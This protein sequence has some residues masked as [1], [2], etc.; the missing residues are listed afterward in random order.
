M[1]AAGMPCATV[2]QLNPMLFI[3]SLPEAKVAYAKLDLTAD[4]TTVAGDKAT[5]KVTYIASSADDATRSFPVEI[6]IDNPDGK[7]RDGIT[8]DA[9]VRVA[10]APVQVLP[11]S[12][13]TLDDNGVL[14]VRTV[15]DGNKVAFHEITIIKDTRDGVWVSNLPAKINLITVG[16]DFVLP[17]QIVDAKTVD[18][19][20]PS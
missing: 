1:L 15:E 12:A 13:L 16:Q 4:V 8:A 11:Q 5:G 20:L 10:M 18:G 9:T 6:T 14:G 7:I 2:V 19:E 17:G 3:A